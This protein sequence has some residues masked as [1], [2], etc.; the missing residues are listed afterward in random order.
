MAKTVPYLKSRLATIE[1]ELE[2]LKEE[3]G[4]IAQEEEKTSS[5]P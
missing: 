5:R 1:V 2:V 3:V 4:K